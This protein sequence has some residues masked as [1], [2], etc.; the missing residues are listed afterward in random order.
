MRKF[1]LILGIGIVA[2]FMT[3]EAQAGTSLKGYTLKEGLKDMF[4]SPA[5]IVEVTQE[6]MEKT[7]GDGMI[8][9][10]VLGFA[11]GIMEGSA[12]MVSQFFRGLVKVITSPVQ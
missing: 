3:F 8:H 9:G 4:T 10:E 5:Q 2:V 12:S 7:K 1:L 6:Q 11:A